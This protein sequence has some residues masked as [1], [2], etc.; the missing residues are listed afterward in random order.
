[1]RAERLADETVALYN[2]AANFIWEELDH[3]SGQIKGGWWDEQRDLPGLIEAE[4][5]DRARLDT[6]FHWPGS[7][8]AR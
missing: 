4:K 2:R 6:L 7:G 5:Q 1:V 3:R 8:S